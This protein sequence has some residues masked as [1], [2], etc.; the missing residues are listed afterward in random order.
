[1][2]TL[3]RTFDKRS[4]SAQHE[5]AAFQQELFEFGQRVAPAT[6]IT[7]TKRKGPLLTVSVTSGLVKVA[8]ASSNFVEAWK[9]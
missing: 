7:R 4:K 3:E 9:P 6:I 2:A 8:K 5:L 1:M